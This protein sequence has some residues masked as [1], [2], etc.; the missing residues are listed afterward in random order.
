MTEIFSVALINEFFLKALPNEILAKRK[1]SV[2][3]VYVKPCEIRF[4]ILS[5]MVVRAIAESSSSKKTLHFSRQLK[6]DLGVLFKRAR[7]LFGSEI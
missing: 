3:H 6:N 2:L 1:R 7:N 4:V 5:H